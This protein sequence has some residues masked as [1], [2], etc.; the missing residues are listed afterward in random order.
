MKSVRVRFAPSPTG[1]LHIGGVRTA[2][3]NYLFAKKFK[4]TFILR[5][6][7]TDQNR[8]VPGAEAYII[9]SLRWFGLLPDEG[10]EFGGE[11]GP[12]RQSERKEIYKQYG[13]KL[14]AD[15]NAYYAFD[16]PEELEMMRE[17]DQTFKYDSKSR[18][19]L[20]NS[21]TLP[22]EKVKELL[23]KGE[24]IAV[25][26]KIPENEIISFNDEIRGHVSFESN[27]L[28]D[29]VILKGDGMPTYHLA[30][31]V[32]D[33][34]MEITHV[35]RGEEWLPST[36]HHVLMY[37][38]FGWTPPSFSHLPL[39][40]KPTGQ[41]KLSKRDGAKFGFPVFPLS[42]DS[43]HE[44]DN[45]TGFKDDGFL[46]E[47]VLNFLALLG[48]SPGN[49][50]EMFTLPELCE[51]F[52]LD[53]ITKSGARF[54][55]DKAKW[56]NQQYIIHSDNLKLA[57]TVQDKAIDEGYNVSIEYLADVCGLMKE[58]VH[59]TDEIISGG[60]FFFEPPH[61]FDD[62]TI[63]KRYKPENS[64]HFLKIAD[65]I[66]AGEKNEI[67]QIIKGYVQENGLKLGEFMPIL[68][69]ALSGSMQGPDLIQSMMLIGNKES[70]ERITLAVA[71]FDKLF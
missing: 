59:K 71:Y 63:K 68:R 62:E 46:P 55:I 32:D 23:E 13:D 40:L 7:D 44:E 15:G 70:S 36:A 21:L 56:F 61:A 27:E 65:Q 12:Y 14:L 24:N 50:Q 30:N 51:V 58:R 18:K 43:D 64:K 34:L 29:K 4:G 69:I 9:D 38:F 37:R 42:W 2:L 20:K 66:G 35:I 16:T 33:H 1:P 3:Y 60:R 41:G 45:F 54:D 6:E 10:P 48:W 53:K 52:S 17:S 25:R 47:A 5:I 49:D 28:D 26:L 57:Y 39:I 11:Y 67:E 22:P 8:Y 19:V 31:I